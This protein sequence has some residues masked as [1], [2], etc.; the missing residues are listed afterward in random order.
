[1]LETVIK[2]HRLKYV[3]GKNQ[4]TW[5]TMVLESTGSVGGGG[6]EGSGLGTSQSSFRQGW[7]EMGKGA[8]TCYLEQMWC[9][10][11]ERNQESR[12]TIKKKIP[13]SGQYDHVVKNLIQT[14]LGVH[15]L[16]HATPQ[17]PKEDGFLLKQIIQLLLKEC[18]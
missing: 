9:L 10:G 8:T 1:M 12:V 18:T 14:T 6:E 2:F 4:K 15:I 5:L 11:S 16:I 7:V 17:K 3:R 13:Q